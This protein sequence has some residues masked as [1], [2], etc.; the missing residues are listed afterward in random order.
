[1]SPIVIVGKFVAYSFPVFGS[2]EDGPVDPLQPPSILEQ[3]T[4]NLFVSI[5]FP[6]PINLS[7][8]PIIPSCLLIPAA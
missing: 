6:S 5:P 3:I 4:K 2:I 1:M 7:H 8:Q